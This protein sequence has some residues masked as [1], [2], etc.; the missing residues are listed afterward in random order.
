[1]KNEETGEHAVNTE[2]DLQ[3]EKAEGGFTIIEDRVVSEML[4]M[5]LNLNDIVLFHLIKRRQKG[6]HNGYCH[7]GNRN[8]SQ[9]IGKTTK[10][11]SE[12]INKL[13]KLGL[14]ESEFIQKKDGTKHRRM[15]TVDPSC[16]NENHSVFKGKPH[17]VKTGKPIP[18]KPEHKRKGKET[19]VREK[20]QKKNGHAEPDLFFDNEEL[21]KTNL[22]QTIIDKW[23][24]LATNLPKC[25]K[26]NADRKSKIKT[27]LRE[28]TQED[29]EKVFKYMNRSPFFK[30]NQYGFDTAIVPSRFLGK[31]EK[32]ESTDN[33]TK[34]MRG[35]I[36][37][38]REEPQF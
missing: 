15:R 7:A 12:M 4:K 13:V 8:L 10:W 22:D 30:Q 37:D 23:N 38:D 28:H 9:Q 3:N 11:T 6:G 5:R 26:L 36:A 32:A 34:S 31:L 33:Q 21:V 25:R 27:L 29:F 24:E 2:Y 18:K 35:E 16:K 1:M 14:I 19:I 20:K 17:P